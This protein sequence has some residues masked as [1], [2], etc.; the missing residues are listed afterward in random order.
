MEIGSKNDEGLNCDVDLHINL[1]DDM[2]EIIA[3]EENSLYEDD[4]IGYD[5]LVFQFYNDELDRAVSARIFAT[6]S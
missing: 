3:S 1:Y 5:T 4:F 2:G 6:K